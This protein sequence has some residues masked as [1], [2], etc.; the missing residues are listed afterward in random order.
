MRGKLVRL[1]GY[2][3]SDVDA[4]MRW[5]SDEEVTS[6]LGPWDYPVTRAQQEQYVENASRNDPRQK[7]FAIETLDGRII[8]DCGLRTINWYN[9]NAELFITIGEKSFWGKGY[10]T[11]AVRT[12]LRL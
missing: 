11:D 2:E 6:L 4:L 7:A 9:R 10:G 5:W 1:R 3:K 12:L 8:G